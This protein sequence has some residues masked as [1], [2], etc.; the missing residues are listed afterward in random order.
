MRMT[1]EAARR[2]VVVMAMLDGLAPFLLTES[3]ERLDDIADVV[4]SE[5]LTEFDS[6]RADALL[7]RAEV[8]LTG[9]GC[10]P[11]TDDVLDR[12]PSLRLVAHAAGTVKIH[13]TPDVFERGIAVTS[14]AAA[15]AVPVAEF[16]LAAIL[17]ANK[18]AF[19]MSERYRRGR[20]ALFA[21]LEAGNRGKVVGLVGASRVGRKLI[22]LLRPFE[23]AVL[24][25][26]PHLDHEGARALG[27]ELVELTD[28][29]AR[30]DV[31]SLH[32][33]P[34]FETVH[35]IG[36]DQLALMRDGATLVNTA[37]GSLVDHDALVAELESGRLN[38]VLDVTDPEP[39]PADSPLYEL[40][41]AFLTPHVSGATGTEMVRLAEL[42]IDEIDRWSRGEPLQHEVRAEDWDHIA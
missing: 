13:V 1:T 3:R 31:V 6:E 19:R 28:L 9:W 8:L 12:A 24:V 23:L 15:N 21:P 36:C 17:F 39:L 42:A 35:M 30:S 10:P 29:L 41:N 4:D 38:A 32:A 5:P 25:Y 26:D 22:E 20:K 18:D 37:R 11:L 2:P 7:R 33:P 27:V 34:L 40:P 14:A 16:A